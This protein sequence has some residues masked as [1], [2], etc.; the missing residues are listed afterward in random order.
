MKNYL[1]I[2]AK[3]VLQLIKSYRIKIMKRINN[4]N[5]EEFD[6]LEFVYSLLDKKYLYIG[7]IVLSILRFFFFEHKFI[8]ELKIDNSKGF[9][10]RILTDLAIQIKS[11]KISLLDERLKKKL[12]SLPKEK[13]TININKIINSI[14]YYE[15]K[16]NIGESFPTQKLELLKLSSKLMSNKEILKFFNEKKNNTKANNKKLI[17]IKNTKTNE[18]KNEDKDIIK[19]YTYVNNDSKK[20]CKIIK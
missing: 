11:S 10:K 18:R 7:L 3:K 20:I 17:K 19:I 2:L 1:K 8:Y 14:N 6:I 5:S 15:L 13:R 4:L 9:E 12:I 16:N